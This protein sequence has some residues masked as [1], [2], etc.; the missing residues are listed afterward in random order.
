MK[1]L[2]TVIIGMGGHAT[3]WRR[4]V[5]EHP[6]FELTGIVDT[7]TELLDNMHLF[8]LEEDDGFVSI[9]DYVMDKGVP[10][11][12]IICTP[13]YT[14]HVLVKETMDHGINVICEKNMASTIYQG[15][16]MVQCAIDNPKL[17]TAVGHQYRYWM[18]NWL[19]K[20][21]VQEYNDLGQLG[22]IRCSS[23]GNW[24]EK[25]RGWRRWLQEVYLEDMAPHHFDLIRYIT[26]LDIVQVKADTFIPKFSPWQGSSTVFASL[27]IAHP[28]DYNHRHNWI[29]AE[30]YG[31]WQARG[32]SRNFFDF[33]FEKGQF[34][35][36]GSWLEIK[37]YLDE[38][39]RKWEDDGFLSI[40][41]GNDGVEHMGTNY[42]GQGIILEQVKRSIESGGKN[43]PLNNFKDIFKSFAVSMGAIESSRTGKAVWIP[44]Y[45]K[46]IPEL[47]EQ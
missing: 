38:D 29:W 37:R 17:T 47:C 2:S 1:K 26:G 10:D 5:N 41:A 20:C 23:A 22:Y 16:Q 34:S 46:D 40:D 33:Y 32:P 25:R 9:D 18:H 31:D 36:S 45:W 3:S 42:T 27:A 13:I 8:G 28:D 43:Q 39:G 15:K 44:D 24:G 4:Q 6:A 14:H 35:I 11:V 30:Y 7:D 19:A 12:A 21:F